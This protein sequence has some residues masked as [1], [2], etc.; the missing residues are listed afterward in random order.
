[1]DNANIG[2]TTAQAAAEQQGD[3]TVQP[4][5]E[6]PQGD[7]AGVAAGEEKGP[8]PLE[9]FQSRLAE[10]VDK[11]RGVEQQLERLQAER[12]QFL[13]MRQQT[14]QPTSPQDPQQQFMS[15]YGIEP[16][17]PVDGSTVYQIVQNATQ[18]LS[19]QL[20]R[21]INAQN[22][23][24]MYPDMPSVVGQTNPMTGQFLPSKHFTDYCNQNPQ[25]AQKLYMLAQVP[26]GQDVV[27]SIVKNS[28]G[29]SQNRQDEARQVV[30]Q[31][32]TAVPSISNAGTQAQMDEAQIRSNWTDEQ[33]RIH[34]EQA[35]ARAG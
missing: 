17:I 25:L 32:N 31:K 28:P 6:P 1:M 21:T 4:A 10:E 22:I 34:V 27:Y 24:Q 29:Y 13:Q 16:D 20:Q 9:K 33:V 30:Q 3:T 18:Q 14:A 5:P 11:R 7:T 15:Q 12:E 26:E 8:V 23:N 35:K 2:D 19:Q